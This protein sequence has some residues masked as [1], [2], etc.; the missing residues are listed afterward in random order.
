MVGLPPE[1]LATAANSASVRPRARCNGGDAPAGSATAAP[2]A[3]SGGRGLIADTVAVARR[4]D[5]PG[6]VLLQNGG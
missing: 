2:E 3:G 6:A 4:A 1:N 5:G